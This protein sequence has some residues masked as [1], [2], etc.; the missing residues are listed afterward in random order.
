MPSPVAVVA[1]RLAKRTPPRGKAGCSATP[2]P[3]A[4]RLAPVAIPLAAAPSL[5]DDGA[6]SDSS[7]SSLSSDGDS[8]SSPTSP[9]ASDGI[10]GIQGPAGAPLLLP[11]TLTPNKVAAISHYPSDAFRLGNS[12]PQLCMQQ[13]QQQ[14]P[15]VHNPHYNP[16]FSTRPYLH[17]EMA[18][19]WGGALGGH[20]IDAATFGSH[21][22]PAYSAAPPLPPSN[23]ASSAFLQPFEE[24]LE[25]W[26]DEWCAAPQPPRRSPAP[27][28]RAR[29]SPLPR[30]PLA[31]DARGVRVR[32]A[33][34]RRLCE[35]RL[36][37]H[38]APS[39][40][41]NPLVPTRIAAAADQHTPPHSTLHAP[42]LAVLS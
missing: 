4:S 11:R 32:H 1:A 3:P 42:P 6:E 35:G 38:C 37:Q 17:P 24:P 33:P 28:C 18:L 25:D 23:A 2:Q 27:R 12:P 39:R 34:H 8:D 40:P 19:G 5:V 20:S 16:Y 30:A 7:D 26:V 41:P 36:A 29:P 14:Q 13:Q 9:A 31:A 22:L 10:A 21:P 15:G